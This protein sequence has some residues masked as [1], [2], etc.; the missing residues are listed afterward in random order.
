MFKSRIKKNT[1]RAISTG[2]LPIKKILT[3]KLLIN[4]CFFIFLIFIMSLCVKAALVGNQE[5]IKIDL[6]IPNL[7]SPTEGLEITNRHERISIIKFKDKEDSFA[8]LSEIPPL[9]HNTNFIYMD[10][11]LLRGKFYSMNENDLYLSN[12]QTEF[13][14]IQTRL[15]G[16]LQS[17]LEYDNPHIEIEDV[18]DIYE[19]VHTMSLTL[20][21][22]R[23]YAL[24]SHQRE[25]LNDFK[26]LT[27]EIIARTSKL[28]TSLIRTFYDD[29]LKYIFVKAR[30]KDPGR[31]KIKSTPLHT[32][33][34]YAYDNTGHLNG[35]IKCRK[36]YDIEN[37]TANAP[38]VFESETNLDIDDKEYSHQ[39]WDLNT[40][41]WGIKE[42]ENS[43]N[44]QLSKEQKHQIT[45][46]MLDLKEIDRKIN[47]LKS[48]KRRVFSK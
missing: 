18:L 3:D 42:L 26:I 29:Q 30:I 38:K 37:D 24:S 46:I 6:K 20:E 48:L 19:I 1:V 45:H 41:V 40:L 25:A 31:K 5:I 2:L 7:V 4:L 21:N 34:A 35:K 47:S 27:N 39:V 23:E 44:F 14:E 15:L 36:S 13:E 17:V 43:R 22:N 16:E 33:L 32:L 12:M 10:F 8:I 28:R 9:S 11:P